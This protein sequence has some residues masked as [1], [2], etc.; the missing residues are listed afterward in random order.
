MKA[1]FQIDKLFTETSKH[2]FVTFNGWDGKSYNGEGVNARVYVDP[3]TSKRYVRTYNRGFRC[4]H[5]ILDDTHPV[6]G[7]KML[8]TA[9]VIDN[10]LC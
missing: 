1:I 5:E 9:A 8:L 3:K 7:A 4:Y 10:V 2:E 6:T